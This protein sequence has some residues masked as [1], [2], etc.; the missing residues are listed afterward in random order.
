MVLLTQFCLILSVN[1]VVVMDL[2]VGTG[3]SQSREGQG[4]AL[5]QQDCKICAFAP[6]PPVAGTIPHPPLVPWCCSLEVVVM[7]FMVGTE[8]SQSR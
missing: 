4:L 8:C 6:D 3:C 7:D 2:V 5:M 1:Q